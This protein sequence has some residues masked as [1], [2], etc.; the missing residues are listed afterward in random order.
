M[1]AAFSEKTL[2]AKRDSDIAPKTFVR[3]DFQEATENGKRLRDSKLIN[4]NETA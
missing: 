2:A 1:D 4:Q 3:P